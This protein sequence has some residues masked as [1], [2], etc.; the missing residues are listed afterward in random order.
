LDI[1][2]NDLE[3]K[4][5]VTVQEDTTLLAARQLME[6]QQI[7]HL[8]VLDFKGNLLKVIG[9]GDI[10][11]VI[12]H[13]YVHL[14]EEILEENKRTLSA[15]EDHIKLLLNAVHQT[16]GMILISDKFGNIEYVNKAFEG[17][18]GYSLEE[19]KGLN[20]RFLKSG[21]TQSDTYQNLWQTLKLGQTWKGELCNQTKTG[22]VY[23]VLASITPIYNEKGELNHF[24]AVEEEITEKIE[25]DRKL[26]E[27]GQHFLDVVNAAPIMFWESGSDGKIVYF[28]QYCAEFTGMELKGLYQNGWERQIDPIDLKEYSDIFQRAMIG[29]KAFKIDHRLKN[30]AGE[31]RWVMNN[32]VPYINEN[33][34]FSGFRGFCIDITENKIREITVQNE[35]ARIK[36]VPN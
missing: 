22:R 19:V 3:N 25:R 31:Y 7:R 14:L 18:T 8:A 30:Y 2:I 27:F 35:L 1:F 17:L 9:L 5:L 32:A 20:P 21:Q 12:E 28:N 33:G 16:A 24:V 13:S 4:P 36:R 23:W 15:K 26:K 34:E 29:R 10:L 11:R 6:I